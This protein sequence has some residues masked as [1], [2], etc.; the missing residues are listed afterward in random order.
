MASCGQVGGNKHNAGELS[1]A[2]PMSDA[3]PVPDG[4]RL[5]L[6]TDPPMAFRASLGQAINAFH[7]QTVPFASSRFALE[8]RDQA[9]GLAGG[10]S[11]LM[12]WG[13]LFIDAVWVR[14]DL[15]GKG[16]GSA[17]MAY[18]ERHA[19]AGGCHSVW[20]DTFQARAFYRGLGY[21]EFGALEDYPNGQT[22]Y[23][24]RK[25][26]AGTGLDKPDTGGYESAD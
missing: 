4:F 26:L 17:L 23:F 24:L 11:G 8:L 5:T 3:P 16:A 1:I 13:W 7:G 20:L 10:L 15:R 9:G 2:M 6:D 18:A 12:S 19:A 25:R 14:A 21:S 22:R